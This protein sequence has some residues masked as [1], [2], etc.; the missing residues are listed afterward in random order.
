MRIVLGIVLGSFLLVLPGQVSAADGASAVGEKERVAWLKKHV[1][2][3]H[4]IDPG[5]EDFS[6]LEPIRKAIGE[7]R[8]VY[9]SEPSHGD[10]A[11]F[12]AR[13][14]LIKFLHQKCGFEVLAFESGL[15]DCRKAWALLR[16][17]KMRPREAV[18]QGVFGIWT[19][20]EQVQ[21]LIEYLGRQARGPRPLEICGFDCQFSAPASSRY[22]PGELATVLSQVPTETLSAKQRTAAVAGCKRLTAPGAILDKGQLEAFAACRKALAA[23]KPT[24][25]L[26]ALELAFWQRH[27]ENMT[28]L[29]DIFVAAQERPRRIE[30]FHSNIRD[31]QMA[32]NLAWLAHDL[33]PRRKIIVWAHVFH[34]MRNQ[35]TIAM[36]VEPD[37]TSA[38]R[39]TVRPYPG[40]KVMGDEAHKAL[41]KET[42][43]LFFTAAEGEW[44]TVSD[45]EPVKLKPLIA[46]SL[47]DLLVKAG[48]ENAF[49]DFRSRGKDG[50]WLATRLIA[51]FLGNMD[52]EADW[53]KIC[54]GLV[55]TRKQTPST[56]VKVVA[57][58]TVEGQYLPV[59]DA[60]DLG[61]PFERF[62]TRDATGRTI[63][64]YLSRPPKGSAE[65][66]PLAIFVQG[67]GC[68]SV[69][70]KKDGK[71]VGGLQ[72]LL[73]AAGK[74]RLRVLVV[75]KPGVRFGD[76]PKKPGSA[77]EGS[78][79]FRKEH[80]LPRWVEAINAA[81]RAGQQF[82]D[83]D[84]CRTLV[85]GHSEGGIVAAHLA[86]ANPHVTHVALLAGGGPTQLFDLLELAAKPRRAEEPAGEARARVRRIQEGWARVCAD[87]DNPDKLW[88]GHPHRRWTSFLKTSTQ[89]GLLASRTA[90]FLAQGTADASV[91][92][93]GFDTL[94]AEL[95]AR[96]RD[97]TAERLEGADHAFRKPGAAPPHPT[98]SPGGRGKGEGGNIDGFRDVLGRAAGW[99]LEKS[100]PLAAE[101]R[102]ELKRLEGNWEVVS[103]VQDG[104][105]KPLEGTLKGLS[106]VMTS[107]Q[108]TLRAGPRVFTQGAYR[109]DPTAR[110][111]RIDVTITQGAQKGQVLE[112]IYEVDADTLRICLAMK[113]GPRPTE[114][115]SKPESGRT[116]MV[117]KAKRKQ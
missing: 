30:R 88:L 54:D 113:G 41:G 84:W 44:Q 29:A 114:M 3:L 100:E 92:V 72:D 106:V 42:Y 81:V 38:E 94:R 56:P 78:A 96:G 95:I 103:L 34:L 86:A 15:Y 47:D 109:I 59:R 19:G 45:P 20:S 116:L 12:H 58:N 9:L 51:R 79:E 83:V 64:F 61:L 26:P 11:S 39:K 107:D 8:I 99:F 35:D 27:L 65:K 53:T 13:T 10:G 4:S 69:F 28:V 62:T 31:P 32:R 43:S 17:A 97:V 5:N 82:P 57:G 49:L 7:A 18:S 24:A 48:C 52:H 71:I 102:K 60:A 85:V 21:P 90:V 80:T 75:E 22:L 50:E 110:P 70:P 14:R 74:G 77:E 115:V 55:F 23:M 105:D 37:K 108:R 63:T 93:T 6:D 112:G 87:P 101:V 25:A 1:A 16:E 117:H 66:L 98:L 46:G 104:D 2:P 68:A 111:R 67:S 76:H 89:E 73:L 36:V 40:I 33:Y 91:S